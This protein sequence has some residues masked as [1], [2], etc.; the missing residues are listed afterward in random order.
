MQLE[1]Q[2]ER[3]LHEQALQGRYRPNHHQPDHRYLRLGASLYVPGN[4]DALISIANGQK[5]PNLRSVIFCTEDSVRADDIP[6]V[7]RNVEKTLIEMEGGTDTLRFIRVRSPEVLAQCLQ[8]SCINKIDGFV[9]P[10]ITRQ[11]LESYLNQL[12]RED[13]FDVMITLETP[14][15]FDQIEMTALRSMLLVPRN[16]KRILSIRI[17]G[18]DLLNHI[19]MRRSRE[20]TLYDTPLS[21]TISMLVSIFKPYGFNLTAPVCDYMNADAL[22]RRECQLDL[23]H[24]LFGKTA[25]HPEQ[26]AVIEEQYRVSIQDAEMAEAIL[27]PSRPAVFRMHD[28]MCEPATH[29]NWAE[30]I[31]ARAEIYG[32]IE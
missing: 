7:L 12:R 26:I 11:N 3:T 22:L 6:F 1:T 19:G 28:A 31:L 16:H 14:E 25:I 29:A 4:H 24:G 5:Y 30:H 8:M 10:K 2:T 20:H 9:L 23:A 27:D 21:H 32:F 18:N 15:A 13:H 17:G